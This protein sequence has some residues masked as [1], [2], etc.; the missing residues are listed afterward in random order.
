MDWI[1]DFL[2]H[3]PTPVACNRIRTE[4]FF[5]E[6]GSGLDLDFVFT[7]KTLLVV[8]LTYIFRTQTGVGLFESG[9]Y[10]IGSGLKKIRVRT[11]LVGCDE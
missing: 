11:P 5:P 4:V 7:E 2:D 8:C 3:T 6:A 10:R 9:W 1:L